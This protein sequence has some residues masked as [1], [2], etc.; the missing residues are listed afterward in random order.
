M[1]LRDTQ[2][3]F[4]RGQ[5]SPLLFGRPDMALYRAGLAEAKN[6]I[7]YVQGPMTRMPGTRYIEK[8]SSQNYAPRLIPFKF[9]EEQS[10]ALWFGQN[11]LRIFKEN[12]SLASGGSPIVVATPWTASQLA[13]LDFR[14][15]KDVV[16]IVDGTP[17]VRRL[18]RRA[19]DN[20]VFT[21]CTV[22]N[23]PF[24]KGNTSESQ[25]FSVTSGTKGAITNFSLSGFTLDPGHVGCLFRLEQKQLD[26][27]KS[28]SSGATIAANQEIQWERRV[29]RAVDA[30]KTSGIAPTHTVGNWTDSG[31]PTDSITW[32]YLYDHYGIVEIL[33]VNGSGTG[34][35]CRVLRTVPASVVSV[36]TWVWNEGA[37]SSYRGGP[38]AI[39]FKDDRL[40]FATSAEIHG[41]AVNGY[42][43]ELDFDTGNANNDDAIS[44]SPSQ[45]DPIR[46]MD[47]NGS[48]ILGTAGPPQSVSSGSTRQPIVPDPTPSNSSEGGQ[49]AARIKPKVWDKALLYISSDK[50]KLIELVYSL[51][52][53][54]FDANDLTLASEDILTGLAKELDF[55][56]S[57][58]R[59]ATVA[60]E[61]GGFVVMTYD[62]KNDVIG[63][64]PLARDA[65]VESHCVIPASDGVGDEL[66]LATRR[67]IN[68]VSVRL[69][70]KMMPPWRSGGSDDPTMAWYLDCALRKTGAASTTVSGLSHL[71]GETVKVFADGAARDDAVVSGGS[72]TLSKPAETV[73][74]GLD[75][76]ASARTLPVQFALEGGSSSGRRKTI[77]KMGVKVLDTSM[78]E[79][80]QH[81]RDQEAEADW[82][83]AFPTQGGVMTS[84]RKTREGYFELP[85]QT[86]SDEMGQVEIRSIHGYPMTILEI[87]PVF[88]LE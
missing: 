51:G 64:W 3:S 41:T 81:W 27:A 65:I 30:G 16:Y 72:I 85:L 42:G 43:P 29:Y 22:T 54:A 48:L 39:A 32:T 47:E 31:N 15:S 21:T 86:R 80:R 20:W 49:G 77:S 63:W 61:N 83:L 14:Q 76:T 75:I 53:E 52:G 45:Q 18:E 55:M 62:R 57:P 68:G 79:Y 74:V 10:Y 58:F 8:P 5:V 23:G 11:E 44:L 59:I 2:R 6:M 46:W 40:W 26:V 69:V 19:E 34:G 28:W 38:Q 70:E 67:T 60:M 71:N 56:R 24:L 7:G 13:S 35:T 12:G 73:L 88:D 78:L 87:S 1:R 36:G 4:T 37:W 82:E 25:T 84:Y 50:Q 33:S 9:G 66:W 17:T